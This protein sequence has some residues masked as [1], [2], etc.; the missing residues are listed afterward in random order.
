M[1]KIKVVLLGVLFSILLV[2]CS[3]GSDKGANANENSSNSD[4]TASNETTN[5]EGEETV[6]IR[7]HHWYNEERD[8]WLDIIET[9][10]A[11]HP[12][13]KV[14]SVTPENNDSEETMKQIDLAAAS[15]DQLDVIMLSG[16]APY[17]QR[18]N[19]GMFEPLNSYLEEEGVEFGQE[20]QV[21]TN[22]EGTYYGLPGKYNMYFVMLNENALNEAGL[23]I[24]TDWT[25]DEYMDYAAQLT[26]GEGAN[27]RYGTYF[28][29]WGDYA[30]LTLNNQSENSNLVK[31]DGVTSNID[32]PLIRKT[33]EIRQRGQEEGSATPYGD[34]ISMNLHYY[35]QY[36]NEKAAM[37]MTGSWMIHEGGGREGDP[38]SFK[39]A[40]APYPKAK[41]G[42]PV[43]SPAS[44]DILTV[45][46]GSKHKEE[47]YE[48][49]RW[50]TTQGIIEQ[51][52]FLPS[53]KGEDLTTVVDNLLAG[54][55]NLEMINTESLAN[56]IETTQAADVNVPVP[57][58]GE[59]E[60]AY[61]SEVDKFLLNE[62]DLDTTIDNAHQAVQEVIDANVN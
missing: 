60:D 31:D 48:F 18:V 42:D 38:S 40:F 26:E 43:T 36:F 2:G 29:S 58:I 25:W 1:E 17:S 7:L 8:N 23:E 34:T 53:Y 54:N 13:I 5:N 30:K 4:E 52:K 56:T 33:L 16:A 27:K 57:F 41:E 14:E 46:S 10:E 55:H 51:G 47:A 50:Y 9:F 32:N 22:I 12:N 15:G 62:Q 61:L 49:I 59:V 3:S 6:T 20:Y 44:S 24:P 37:I 39:T 28:H 21:D 11:E 35:D 45:Y 19:Q